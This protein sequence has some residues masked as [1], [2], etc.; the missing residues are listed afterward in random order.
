MVQLNL[1]SLNDNKTIDDLCK[2]KYRQS[3]N[4]PTHILNL[5]LIKKNKI[6]KIEEIKDKIKTENLDYL[7][8]LV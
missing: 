5:D 7:L 3:D 2:I 8:K 6:I 1:I 4:A